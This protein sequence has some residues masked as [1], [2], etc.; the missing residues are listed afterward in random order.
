LEEFLGILECGLKIVKLW[1]QFYT[2]GEEIASGEERCWGRWHSYIF[3]K[4]AKFVLENV[5]YNRPYF[6]LLVWLL[7]WQSMW[8]VNDHVSSVN[9]PV[10]WKDEIDW[11][12]TNSWTKLIFHKIWGLFWLML[13]NSG[14]KLM[15]RSL[16]LLFIWLEY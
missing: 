2:F 9:T 3:C 16:L 12:F 13:A 1:F 7:T 10:N 8:E 4:S 15:I 11:H 6:S 14:T 5:G